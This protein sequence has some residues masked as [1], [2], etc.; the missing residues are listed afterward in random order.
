MLI[1]GVTTRS[2]VVQT[3]TNLNSET[4]W[5]NIHTNFVSFWYTNTPTANDLQRYY[6]A[7]TN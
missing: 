7:I 3:S 2:Y 6:R 1:S 4:N 5:H